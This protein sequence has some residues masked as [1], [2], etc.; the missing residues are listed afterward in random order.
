MTAA[1]IAHLLELSA[2][3]AALFYYRKNKSKPTFYLMLFLGF[4]VCVEILGWYTILMDSGYLSFL[5]NSVFQKNYWLFNIYGIISYLFYINY[6]KWHLTSRDSVRILNFSSLL[7][8]V[9][10]LAEIAFSNDFFNIF[11]PIFRL[12]GTF[13]VLL[14]ISLYYLELLRSEQIL[15]VQKSLPFYVSVGALIFHLC[16]TPL[17]IYS[18]YFSNSIDPGFVRLYTLVIFGTNYLFYSIYIAGFLIC[19][20]KKDPYFPRKNF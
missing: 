5:K 4:T 18:S 14:S 15:Q 12:L 3:I 13:L 7:L 20:R 11:L 19:S 6:F 1:I 9:A 17:F 16:T 10:S 2:F 8:I